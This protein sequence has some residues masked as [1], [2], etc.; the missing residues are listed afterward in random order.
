MLARFLV[1]QR[2]ARNEPVAATPDP[3][4]LYEQGQPDT[5]KSGT[6]PN[7]DEGTRLNAYE[8]LLHD[9][10]LGDRTLFTRADGIGWTWD[11]VAPIL[12]DPPTVHTY[13]DGSWGPQEGLELIS[14]RSW[15]LPEKGE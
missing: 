1:A 15:H 11:L 2:R 12:A 10:L 14:P 5:L 4:P 6:G 3:T 13:D 8:R 7:V 9:A